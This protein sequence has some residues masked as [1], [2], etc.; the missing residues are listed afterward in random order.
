MLLLILQQKLLHILG[1][2]I[3]YTLIIGNICHNKGG[4]IVDYPSSVLKEKIIDIGDVQ[5][6]N[7]NYAF[8]HNLKTDRY[9]VK[10]LPLAV[11]GISVTKPI[12]SLV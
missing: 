9:E 7:S 11:K 10:S 6:N 5:V 1:A 4:F 2:V 3:F 8:S 12:I